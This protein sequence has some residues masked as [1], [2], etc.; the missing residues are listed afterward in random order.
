MATEPES[1]S[2]REQPEAPAAEPPKGGAGRFLLVVGTLLALLAVAAIVGAF[3]VTSLVRRMLGDD[4]TRITQSV[5]VER[6][7]AVARLVTSE[8]QVRDVV[9]YEN[10]RLGS[11]KRAIVVVTGRVMAGVDLEQNPVVAIDEEA[12]RINITLP[13]ARVLGV[14]VTTLSTYDEDRGL[15]NPFRPADRDSIFMLAREQLEASAGELGVA[16]HAEESA[17][18]ILEGL[19]GVDGYTVEVTF[20]GRAAT[21]PEI[22]EA[23][24]D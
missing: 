12:K 21:S 3:G 18:R 5:I 6:T 14:E 24:R 23:P 8:T 2:P 15:W 9:T 19:L 11:T 17:E 10:R 13:P 4:R 16:R 7:R 20:R 1:P 22:I